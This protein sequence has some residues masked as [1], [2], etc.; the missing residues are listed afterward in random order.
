MINKQE[1]ETN[2][3]WVQMWQTRRQIKMT[4]LFFGCLR[5]ER[6]NSSSA[7]WEIILI[8]VTNQILWIWLNSLQIFL[9]C[10]FENPVSTF[11]NKK[12]THWLEHSGL[13]WTVCV[14][15]E[16]KTVSQ[17]L[18][19]HKVSVESSRT[20]LTC[21]SCV[22]CCHI[23]TDFLFSL[24]ISH[25][26][27]ITFSG[28]EI[29]KCKSERGDKFLQQAANKS[30]HQHPSVFVSDSEG[31]RAAGH[32][33]LCLLRLKDPAASNDPCDHNQTQPSAELHFLFSLLELFTS[34]LLHDN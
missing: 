7:R 34:E 14:L 17:L 13:K 29:N 4:N 23:W 27:I 16:H 18:K 28:C 20:V 25:L 5:E 30:L 33:W 8:P 32:L 3:N 10:T 15:Y 22:F 9:V 11:M 6:I 2:I 1:G 19:I 21:T 26:Q 24:A 12:F 31:L